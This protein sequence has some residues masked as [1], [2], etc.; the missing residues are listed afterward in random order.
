[1]LA[2]A[3]REHKQGNLRVA[4]AS[5]IV[6]IT[7]MP[8]YVV[9][10]SLGYASANL[11]LQ[12]FLAM[13]GFLLPLVFLLGGLCYRAMVSAKSSGDDVSI[14]AQQS[15][16]RGL[17]LVLLAQLWQVPKFNPS[18]WFTANDVS[19]TIFFFAIPLLYHGA[20]AMRDDCETKSLEG[21][22]GLKLPT[23]RNQIA[24]VAARASE[25]ELAAAS[26]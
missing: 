26:P 24:A 12:S 5:A 17:G 7:V 21:R 8:S 13:V 19:H 6:P 16:G 4:Q 22:S 23:N 1:M 3:A 14:G 15:V 2:Y 9:T 11:P 20:S 18:R 10:L 25:T